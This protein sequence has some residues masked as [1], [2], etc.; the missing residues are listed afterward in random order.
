MPQFSVLQKVSFIHWRVKWVGFALLVTFFFLLTLFLGFW[1][2]ERAQQKEVLLARAVANDVLPVTQWQHATNGQ[3]INLTGK[4]AAQFQFLLDNK[5]FDGQAGYDLL[6][7]F[8]GDV[9]TER[10][11]F[12]VNLGWIEA[13]VDRRVLT[14]TSLPTESIDILARVYLPEKKAFRLSDKQFD[15]QGWPKR[16]QYFDPD[17]FMGFVVLGLLDSK[18]GYELR[19]ED[20]QPGLQVRRWLPNLIMPPAKHVAYA[21]QWFLLAFALIVLVVVFLVRHF[22]ESVNNEI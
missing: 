12:W 2:L 7:P 15:N 17:F 13:S 22:K 4:Y 9:G 21:V 10:V 5:P 1:Q 14:F 18:S 3:L 8:V 6:V 19:L 20:H 16:V 11:L